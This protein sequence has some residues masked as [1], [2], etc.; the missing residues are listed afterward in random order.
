LKEIAYLEIEFPVELDGNLLRL[1]AETPIPIYPPVE[2]PPQR[3]YYACRRKQYLMASRYG[4]MPS[5][6]PFLPLSSEKDL[7]L[8]LGSRRDPEP[9]LVEVFAA[10]AA[11]EGIVFLQ[12]GPTLF[13]AQTLPVRYLLFPPVRDDFLLKAS[14]K[15]KSKSDTKTEKP[16]GPPSPGSFFMDIRHFQEGGAGKEAS[17]HKDGKKGG[18]GA[19]WKRAARKERNKRNV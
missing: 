1:K 5:S 10:R 17:Q 4:F 8:R 16:L 7:A 12:A 19:E 14:A 15:S 13:L 2:A 6:R 18:R 11:A 9:L 3:L